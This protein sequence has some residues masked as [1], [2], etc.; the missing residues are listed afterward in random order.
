VG[1]V[2]V[3]PAFTRQIEKFAPPKYLFWL[4]AWASVEWTTRKVAPLDFNAWY[5]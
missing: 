2:E 4:C 5:C 1:F 3:F